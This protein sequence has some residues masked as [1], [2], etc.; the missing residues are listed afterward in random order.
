MADIGRKMN[1]IAAD[2]M[3]LGPATVILTRRRSRLLPH[4]TDS[5]LAMVDD[6]IAAIPDKGLMVHGDYHIENVMVQK[7][8]LVLIDVGGMSCGHPVLD[9]LCLYM[10][11][12]EPRYLET[13][14]SMDDCKK[15]WEIYLDEYFAGKLTADH[16]SDIE[17]IL[18]VLADIFMLPAHCTV[19]STQPEKA[20]EAKECIKNRLGRISAVSPE[21]L[22]DLFRSVDVLY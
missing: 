20:K 6:L 10:K 21:Q 8:D 4:L 16:R 17:K 1:G 2:D 11:T 13:R 5:E 12:T 3:G 14:L 19:A 7:G 18:S 9:L 22:K 15:I